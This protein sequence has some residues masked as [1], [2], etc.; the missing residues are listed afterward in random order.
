MPNLRLKD[1]EEAD[2]SAIQAVYAHHVLHG[3][4]SFEETP[5]ETA[6]MLRRWHTVR[7]A[8][9]PYLVCTSAERG[10]AIEGFA[11]AAAYRL[12]PAYRFAVEDSVYVD[13]DRPRRG[14]GRLLLSA[15]IERCTE[16]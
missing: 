13:P 11:Y 10:G 2:F 5:P 14:I 1:A 3:L 9:L 6:E 7:E 16:L 8:G 15:L 12:R 4:G